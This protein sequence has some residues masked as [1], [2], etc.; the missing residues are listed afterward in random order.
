VS[1]SQ[2]HAFLR[3]G[4]GA[5]HPPNQ[6][7]PFLLRLTPGTDHPMLNY[8]VP[9]DRVRP[10]GPEVDAL[11]AAFEERGLTPR[12]EYLDRA[13][14]D[15]E[16]ILAAHGFTVEGHLPIMGCRPGPEHRAMAAPRFT[17][18]RAQSDEDHADALVVAN[19]AYGEPAGPP[20][21][22]AVE[23]RQSE[24]A[25]GGAVVLARHGASG[26]AAGSGL[27]AAPRD[28]VSELAAIGTRQQF[29]GR[30]VATAVTSRLVHQAFETGIEFL[31]LTA[32]HDQE[33]RIL[34]RAGFVRLG[35][36]MIHISKRQINPSGRA[37]G[38]SL[39][40]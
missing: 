19:E 31:W 15:L 35:G 12:L 40:S 22:G 21:P 14:P 5:R 30:G 36:H 1:E 38:L 3:G 7:G 2:I 4:E 16:A 18:A 37:P 10:T 39:P 13:A 34:T 33:E 26:A 9:D 23:R 25:A 32:E 6:V 11:T 17:V 29:R 27:F 24:T 28:G 8:A 20:P